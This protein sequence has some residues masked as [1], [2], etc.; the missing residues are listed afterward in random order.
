MAINSYFYD[1]V[2]GD[3]A[4]SAQ[5]FSNA[6]DI[7]SE[8]GILSR[9]DF[10][11]KMG[12]DIGGTNYTTLYEGQA[13][14]KGRFVEVTGT[15]LLTVPTGSYSGQ[16][17]IRI[18]TDSARIAS[19]VVKN[20]R[21]PIQTTSLYELPLYDVN[22]TNGT[23]TGAIDK[24]IRGGMTSAESSNVYTKAEIDSILFNHEVIWWGHGFMDQGQ[25][26]TMPK[27][28]SE[29]HNGWILVWSDYDF[30]VG[31]TDTGFAYSVIPKSIILTYNPNRDLP[32][33]HNY[34]LIPRDEYATDSKKSIVKEL[35]IG[36][37]KIQGTDSNVSD[38]E[39]LDVVLRNVIEF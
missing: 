16:I 37:Y 4:Y 27:R 10:G 7:V 30:E 20:D 36:D 2:G 35:F 17:V 34:F 26:L 13:I 29:C 33:V 19:I 8:T 5:D 28:L 21:T 25:I 1:S 12:F 22:V 31:L 9:K 14:I 6:F 15:E 18:D 24:R 32:Q 3:R 23:I 38:A 39:Q 11:G